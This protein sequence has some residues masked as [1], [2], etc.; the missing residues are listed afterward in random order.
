MAMEWHYRW[1][2]YLWPVRVKKMKSLMGDLEIAWENGRKVLNSAH[3]NQSFGSLHHVWQATFNAIG[4][5]ERYV[6][7]ILML[8]LGAGSILHILR[9]ELFIEAPLTII[10]MDPVMIRL[11]RDEFRTLDDKARIIEGDATIQVHS[12]DKA[13]SLITVDLFHDLDLAAGSDTSGFA[14]ALATRCDRNGIVCFNTVGYDPLSSRRCDKVLMH[15]KQHF[16]KVTEFRFE[17]V[18]RVFI[19]EP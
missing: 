18:N 8:G 17:G 3:G 2:S 9:N 4:L 11:A 5:K 7:P 12:I 13:F 10:E 6:G 16:A 19:A 1:L 15:L 14:K